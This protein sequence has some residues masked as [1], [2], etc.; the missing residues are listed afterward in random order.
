MRRLRQIESGTGKALLGI[1]AFLLVALLATIVVGVAN[2]NLFWGEA[3][4]Y[5]NVPIPGKAVLKLP[6]GDVQANVAAALPGRG[7]QT[8]E[9]SL[10]DL[11]LAVIPAAHE[12]GE[13]EVSEDLGGSTN[14]NGGGVDT[15][16]RV[17]KVHL[18]EAGRYLV[19]VKGDFSG[20]GVNAQVR[21]GREP[22]PIHGAM[23]PLVGALIAAVLFAAAFLVR[24]FRR[25][26][27]AS[28]AAAV[29]ERGVGLGEGAPAVD[30]AANAAG[31]HRLGG[32]RERAI[33]RAQEL[34]SLRDSGSITDAV[35]NSER[36]KIE[37]DL[38]R[39]AD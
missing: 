9:M 37:A 1:G 6:S 28:A 26:R 13:P 15:Q 25:S 23:V 4:Q 30:E 11:T 38:H 31:G 39:G 34:E 7:N 21:L 5:G 19:V 2:S 16:R 3:D 17:W 8:P 14:A 22:A 27:V 12:S 10:P 32:A 36:A 24:L 33:A 29:G 18:P 35:Y 20:Y